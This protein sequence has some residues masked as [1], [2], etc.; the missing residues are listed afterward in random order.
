MN[1]TT[2]FLLF[3]KLATRSYE[4]SGSTCIMSSMR[5]RMRFITFVECICLKDWI[6]IINIL[7]L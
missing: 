7:H 1:T 6:N 2:H 4:L 5:V 3:Q